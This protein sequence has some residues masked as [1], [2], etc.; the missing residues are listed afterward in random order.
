MKEKKGIPWVQES[1]Q[2]RVS[3]LDAS[4]RSRLN[5]NRQQVLAGGQSRKSETSKG[6]LIAGGM[7]AASLLTSII[8]LSGNNLNP[9]GTPTLLEDFDL[10]ASNDELDLYDNMPFYQ[11]LDTEY[12]D[13]DMP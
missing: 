4:T 3:A 11:W 10:L 1:L 9:T 8:V 13:V 7:L 5:Q 2:Q 12:N 6:W